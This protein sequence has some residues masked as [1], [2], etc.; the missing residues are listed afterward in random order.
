MRQVPMAT[1]VVLGMLP[2]TGYGVVKFAKVNGAGDCSSW[3]NACSLTSALQRA[4]SGDEIW[5]QAGT[6]VGNFGVGRRLIGGFAGFETSAAQSNPRA[7]P[8]IL[9]GGHTQTVLY[10][11]GAAY[12]RGFTIANGDHTSGFDDGGGGVA[13]FDGSVT[14]V[15][16]I[17]EHNLGDYFGAAVYVEQG[18]AKFINCIFREN[19]TD[20]GTTTCSPA[21]CSPI[22]DDRPLGAAGVFGKYAGLQ[23]T[24]CL[25]VGNVAVTATAIAVQWGA[26]NI[27]N[28]TF[29]GNRETY[30]ETNELIV[31]DSRYLSIYSSIIRHDPMARDGAFAIPGCARA[32]I[33]HS[34]IE[35]GWCSGPGLIGAD[36]LFSSAANRQYDL[37]ISSPCVNTGSNAFLPTDIGDLDWDGVTQEPIPFDLAGNPR[38]ACGVVDMGAYEFVVDAAADCN[39]NQ[40]PDKCEVAD[41]TSPDCN[42]NDVPDSCDLATIGDCNRNGIPDNCE[43][44]GWVRV[45]CMPDDSCE[46][47]TQCACTAQGGTWVSATKFCAN[48]NCGGAY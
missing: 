38:V 5:V 29:Y 18:L 21:P 11:G 2:G 27:V 7:N 16:C 35:D 15:D 20:N 12:I 10:V 25:F 9:D 46:Q 30:S 39:Q 4:R 41:G 1:I 44:L 33:A 6:Y 17:F 40:I 32:T 34:D 8:T 36:P 13:M 37:R 23:F 48:A 26:V 3:A 22:A 43:S 45:C 42:G 14:F 31:A 47:L 19:G 28:C 24:N